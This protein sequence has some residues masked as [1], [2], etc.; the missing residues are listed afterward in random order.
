MYYWILPAKTADGETAGLIGAAL[1]VNV[2]A[3]EAQVPRPRSGGSSS[4][5]EVAVR[6]SID[7]ITANAIDVP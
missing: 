2:G 3:V 5:P 7:G 6:A 4:T 1:W